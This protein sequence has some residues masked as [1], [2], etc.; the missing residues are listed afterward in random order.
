M[1]CQ[2]VFDKI[3]LNYDKSKLLLI[4]PY[5]S[6]LIKVI[7]QETK[8]YKEL[9]DVRLN[10]STLFLT[11]HRKKD[12][13]Y[14]GHRANQG[15]MDLDGNVY[16]IFPYFDLNYAM[17]DFSYNPGADHI[18][19]LSD[20]Y[21]FGVLDLNLGEGIAGFDSYSITGL[22]TTSDGQYLLGYQ[23]NDSLVY[24]FLTDTFN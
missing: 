5:G 9:Y 18:V 12:I 3:Y 4:G 23:R 21:N 1:N 8:S 2:G 20:D 10:S 16:S 24:R 6:N 11:P 15:I 7:D 13:F 17:V 14:V 19:Y 22:T